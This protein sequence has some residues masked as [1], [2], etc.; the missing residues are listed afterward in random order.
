MHIDVKEVSREIK[1]Y[2]ELNG[3]FD[4]NLIDTLNGFYNYQVTK[5]R[6]KTHMDSNELSFP[7]FKQG[8]L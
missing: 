2:T 7:T 3:R 1:A 8:K 5:E 4:S 6:L